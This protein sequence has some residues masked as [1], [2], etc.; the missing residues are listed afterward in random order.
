MNGSADPEVMPVDRW[1][2]RAGVRLHA[3]DWGGG[4]DQ[5]PVLLLHG[6]GGNALV[7]GEVAP[8]L[9]AGLPG[10][11][12]VAVD[13]RDG[14]RSDH[15]ATG[16]R[17]AD[18]M[19]DVVAIAD[20]LGAGRVSL[21]GHSRGGW[22]AASTAAVYPGRVERIVLVDPA[23][24]TFASPT[25]G[26]TAY[27][28]IFGNLGPF[29]SRDAALDWARNEE[30]DADWNPTRVGAFLDNLVDQPDGTVAGRLPQAAM[31]QLRA[32]R[33]DG[34]SVAY[35]AV[36]APTLLL[37]ATGVAEKLAGRLAY[38]ERIPGTRVEHVAGTHFL[39]TDA[40][41]TVARLVTEHLAG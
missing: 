3:L 25:A 28:W 35:E 38:A 10:R 4:T 19:D 29:P 12:V 22:L 18:F 20:Q 26:D 31:Q 33:A 40:P 37:V 23:P 8:R 14:G 34:H 6:V 1:F 7:W 30:P 17:L 16:Y 21:V 24:I 2:S 32:A 11:R 27:R 39:H 15:P 36:V 41:E 5:P 9:R 13:T